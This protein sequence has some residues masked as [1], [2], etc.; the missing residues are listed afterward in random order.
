MST[1]NG[2]IDTSLLEQLRGNIVLVKYGGN[3]MINPTAGENVYDQLRTLFDLGVKVVLVHGGG[4][5]IRNLLEV[6]G[7]TSEF[8]GGHRKT[9]AEAM[10]YVEMALNGQVNGEIVREL[11]SRGVA[12]V[13]L[14]GKDASMVTASRRLH[15]SET[16]NGVTEVDLGFVGNVKSVRTELITWLL[17]GGYLPV[18]SPVAVGED[19]QNY[20]INADMFAGHLAGALQA[21]AMVAMTDVDGL[22]ENVDDP[23]SIQERVSVETVRKQMGTVIQG[24]MIPKIDACLVALEKG[25]EKVHII[26]GMTSDSL[27]NKLLTHRKGGTTI[28]I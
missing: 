4:P 6:A 28:E 7:V 13:G 21:E 10:T 25:V 23:S 20:N 9:D 1:H 27:I 24:G 15:K 2:E 19:H 5:Y 18:V 16:E 14:S 11:G 3:A 26:N 17:D 22:L 12:A 8:I